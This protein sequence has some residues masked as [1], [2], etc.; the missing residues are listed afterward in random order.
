MEGRGETLSL[1]SLPCSL[2]INYEKKNMKKRG[3]EEDDNSPF[4]YIQHDIA[5]PKTAK[6]EK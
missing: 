6:R 4:H 1:T 3:D 5:M 2:N